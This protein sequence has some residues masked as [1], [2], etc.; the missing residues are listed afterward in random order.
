MFVKQIKTKYMNKIMKLA[1]IWIGNGVSI[2]DE[3]GS[4]TRSVRV[5]KGH[6]IRVE[7]EVI[8]DCSIYKP[9]N[10]TV[11]D[12]YGDVFSSVLEIE[13]VDNAGVISRL[14]IKDERN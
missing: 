14:R 6:H 5:C 11:L 12:C 9:A 1:A 3:Y 13:L 7:D 10:Y 8:V 2:E 4:L